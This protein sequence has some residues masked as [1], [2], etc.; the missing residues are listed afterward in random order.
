MDTFRQML[1][2]A[3][4][5]AATPCFAQGHGDAAQDPALQRAIVVDEME[6]DAQKALELYR[7]VATDTSSPDAVQKAAWLRIARLLQRTG[8]EQ[9]AVDAAYANAG[10]TAEKAQESWRTEVQRLLDNVEDTNDQNTRDYAI[11]RLQWFGQ[12]VVKPLLDRLRARLAAN[13]PQGT[14][15]ANAAWTI[16]GDDIEAF[17]T[18]VLEGDDTAARDAIGNGIPRTTVASLVPLA[19]RYASAPNATQ[20]TVLA[21][22]SIGSR[23]LDGYTMVHALADPRPAVQRATLTLLQAWLSSSEP[24]AREPQWLDALTESLRSVFRGG[25]ADGRREGF[26]LLAKVW[27][28]AASTRRLY[29]ELLP[30]A[31]PNGSLP[32]VPSGATIPS[33]D[34]E[35]ELFLRAAHALGPIVDG[36]PSVPQQCAQRVL[37]TFL[38]LSWGREALPTVLEAVRLGYADGLPKWLQDHLKPEDAPAVLDAMSGHPESARGPIAWWMANQLSLPPASWTVLKPA[39]DDEWVLAAIGS[40]GDPAAVAFLVGRL[41]SPESQPMDAMRALVYASARRDAD[42]TRA[43]LR[44]AAQSGNDSDAKWWRCAAIGQLIRVGDPQ[45]ANVLASALELGTRPV[46]GNAIPGSP[47]WASARQFGPFDWFVATASDEPGAKTWHGFSPK[48]YAF[49]LG[50]VLRPDDTFDAAWTTIDHLPDVPGTRLPAAPA[51]RAYAEAWQRRLGHVTQFVNSKQA[52]GLSWVLEL[53]KRAG[54]LPDDVVAAIRSL[55]ARAFA[56][57]VPGARITAIDTLPPAWPDTWLDQVYGQIGNGHL[58]W[59]GNPTIGVRAVQAL[60]DADRFDPKRALE[61]SMADGANWRAPCWVLS[62]TD[63][64]TKAPIDD[65]VRS[66]CH[67]ESA[68]VRKAACEFLG[69]RLDASAVP[70]L[71]EALSD[72][73][74]AVAQAAHDALQA[75]RF[76]QEQ[77]RYWQQVFSGQPDVTAPSAAAALIEQAKPDNDK[78][79][80]LLAIR[81]LGKLGVPEALPFLIAWSKEDDQEI[82][83][84]ARDATSRI[85]AADE[86]P[87]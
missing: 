25:D 13:D 14:R 26:S 20:E 27:A 9:K 30:S 46:H 10:T 63:P 12:D 74:P 64:R 6:H 67:N 87:R 71:L 60:I 22:L 77:S 61:A 58:V 68:D 54:E 37:L 8:A 66:L 3:A 19:V 39:A 57:K 29:L 45:V 16:G 40:T 78:P 4:L 33:S 43:A 21:M 38:S 48:D 41:E 35:R 2:V 15:L 81:S 5:A 52:S 23:A 32:D 44:E 34:A 11:R 18:G 83:A 55:R 84:A 75:I 65:L 69:R 53:E 17:L 80:R 49:V 42:D 7:A 73:D 24:L 56:T 85:L 1:F 36:N 47:Q 51:V 86:K 82:A 79:T 50:E 72:Q 28:S 31:G 76:H 70:T 62:R 59:N